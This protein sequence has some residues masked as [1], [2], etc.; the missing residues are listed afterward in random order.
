MRVSTAAEVAALTDMADVQGNGLEADAS[1][2]EDA[3]EANLA[4]ISAAQLATYNGIQ[5]DELVALQ[6]TREAAEALAM[7]KADEFKKNIIYA[8]HVLKYA[9]SY[10]Y[11]HYVP[12]GPNGL[13]GIDELDV[14]AYGDID[15]AG[16]YKGHGYGYAQ[17]LSTPEGLHDPVLEENEGDDE[18][19]THL[20]DLLA[21]SKQG[22]VDMVQACR[23]DFQAIVD[24]AKSDSA[25]R[26]AG[27]DQVMW[28]EGEAARVV[29]QDLTDA[30]REELS[31]S[32]AAKN[33]AF[34][35]STQATLDA[36]NAE[37]DATIEKINEWFDDRIAWVGT[38]DDEYVKAHLISDLEDA[39][40]SAVADLEARPVSAQEVMDNMRAA[41][42][43]NTDAIFDDLVASTD[44][45][46]A[47]LAAFTAALKADTDA[48]GQAIMDQFAS[49]A[50]AEAAAKNAAMDDLEV[51]WAFFLKQ[52]FNYEPYEERTYAGFNHEQ[53]YSNFPYF[54]YT[55]LNFD[56]AL[57]SYGIPEDNSGYE[58]SLY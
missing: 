5:V 41:L 40:A 20:E 39:R 36:F 11:S 46:L 24:Q 14:E 17:E 6:D 18:H 57:E 56:A 45:D 43:A 29:Q 25:D 49:D 9:N 33:A 16:L 54:D 26:K 28:D 47:D 22:F 7:S 2:Q 1:A 52:E 30:A 15:P 32:N 31:N 48:A 12:K 38:I 55:E 44:A 58:Y 3:S 23:D 37:V 27:V 53:D 13:T 8:V 10:G 34:V 35:D 19:A 21:D 51:K 42:M 50:D 4:A